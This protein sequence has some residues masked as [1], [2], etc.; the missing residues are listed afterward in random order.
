MPGIRILVVDEEDSLRE[1]VSQALNSSGHEVTQ[2]TSGEDALDSFRKNPF[3]LVISDIEMKNMN[4][5]K[6]LQEIKKLR[7]ATEVILITNY[8]SIETAVSALRHEACDYIMKAYDSLDLI[9][10]AVNRAVKKIQY[11]EEHRKM[12]DMLTKQ[13]KELER[14]WRTLKD[15]TA[16]DELTGLYNFRYFH[17]ALE[18]ELIRAGH[19]SRNLS[20]V[21]IDI[22]C[23]K[24]DKSAPAPDEK[25]RLLR[26]V[27]EIV[28]KRLRKSDLLVRYQDDTFA[29]LLPETPRDGTRRVI[30]GIRQLLSGHTFQCREDQSVGNISISM[31]IAVYPEDGTNAAALIY[32][33][34][35][36]LDRAM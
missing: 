34:S 12:L 6:L 29:M 1:T 20:L 10:S 18:V 17:E 32:N 11:S 36:I 24:H 4:G 27:A 7:P 25:A 33:T 22:K 8:P 19:F 16:R 9:S 23:H 13:N 26:S 21:F 30:D 5:I 2:K 31:R 35:S 3:P 15:S 14:T 28:K